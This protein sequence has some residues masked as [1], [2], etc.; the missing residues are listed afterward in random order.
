VPHRLLLLS[1]SDAFEERGDAKY[2]ASP[3]SWVGRMPCVL[4]LLLE[5]MPVVNSGEREAKATVGLSLSY[6]FVVSGSSS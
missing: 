1:H 4:P 6:H 3:L 5:S 2:F